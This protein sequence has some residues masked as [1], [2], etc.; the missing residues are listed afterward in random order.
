MLLVQQPLPVVALLLLLPLL[1]VLLVMPL[2]LLLAV[3]GRR[4]QSLLF[5]LL[6]PLLLTRRRAPRGSRERPSGAVP[7]PPLPPAAVPVGSNTISSLKCVVDWAGS[8]NR[9]RFDS[10]LEQGCGFE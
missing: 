7:T 1:L 4:R 6:L 5:L 2:V 8:I 3:G 10:R 9:S